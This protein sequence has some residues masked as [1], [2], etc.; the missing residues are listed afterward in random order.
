MK[1]NTALNIEMYV[2]PKNRNQLTIVKSEKRAFNY[3]LTVET[4]IKDHSDFVM[5][6][7]RKRTWDEQ[8]V[9]DIFQST[10]LEALKCFS[11]FRGE[12]HPRTWL[13][14]I[15]YNMIRNHA[16]SINVPFMESIDDLQNYDHII[17]HNQFGTEDPCEIYSRNTRLDRLN[18]VFN[19]LPSEMKS[20][21]NEVINR[22]KSYEETAAIF[23]L[24][25][26]TVRSRIARAR[27]IFRDRS[28]YHQ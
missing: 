21:F 26:G 11:K 9:E 4:L 13:C 23:N 6:F 14:G 5:K 28:R 25:I 8:N 16:K 15:A 19:E 12:S 27:E 10:M 20:T 7:I 22:G 3:S 1:N 17:E 2:Q 18:K 24:P